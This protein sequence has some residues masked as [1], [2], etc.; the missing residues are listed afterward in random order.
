M[1]HAERHTTL[2][3][4]IPGGLDARNPNGS[5]E[6]IT[7]EIKGKTLYRC[8][9]CRMFFKRD[10]IWLLRSPFDGHLSWVICDNCQERIQ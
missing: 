6:L 7:K 4:S 9:T 8:N 1:K 2:L 3:A 5:A 10:D